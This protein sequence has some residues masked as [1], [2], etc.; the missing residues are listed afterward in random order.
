[1]KFIGTRRPAESKESD[2]VSFL[3]AVERGLAPDQGLYVPAS[4]PR[5]NESEITDHS[6]HSIAQKVLTPFLSGDL[7]AHELRSIV[8]SAYDFPIPLRYLKNETA[9][10]ELFHGPTA[11]FKDVAA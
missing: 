6:F 2:G 3:E 5:I 10:L 7:T 11:A 4:W 9:V 8:Q 1:M